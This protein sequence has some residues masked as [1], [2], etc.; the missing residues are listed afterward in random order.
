MA[1]DEEI[2]AI[3]TRCMG[4]ADQI[5]REN[6]D[7]LHRLAGALLER[8]ILDAGEI[9]AV[10]RGETLPPPRD[11]GDGRDDPRRKESTSPEAGREHPPVGQ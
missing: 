5:L 11:G 6:M 2:K 1:I 10:I 8:E 9:D 3:V 4:R 7:V